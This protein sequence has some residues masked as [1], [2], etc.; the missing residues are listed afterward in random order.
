MTNINLSDADMIKLLESEDNRNDT[1]EL[2]YYTSFSQK[3]D[4]FG[5]YLQFESSTMFMYF[6]KHE[7]P[8]LLGANSAVYRGLS[9]ANYR[10]FN[11]AQR[12]YKAKNSNNFKD[13]ES[14]HT[15]IA[16][17]ITNAGSVNNGVLPGF[18][19]ATGLRNTHIPILSFL[20]H[21]G[22]PTPFMDWTTD[23]SVALFFAIMGMK[24]D[25]IDRYHMHSVEYNINDYI[26]LAILI[27]EHTLGQINE[28]RQLKATST[29]AASYDKLRKKKF[30][31][32]DE[33]Y[34]SGRPS[35]SLMN[36][37]HIVNQKGL[38]IYHSSS[39]L[40]LEE[41]FFKYW[42][43]YYLINTMLGR[44]T[45]RS[46][47]ICIDIHKS[48]AYHIREHLLETGYTSDTIF[49]KPEEIALKSIPAIF[50]L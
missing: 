44:T 46:P 15:G 34:K 25:E 42:K 21:Y 28:F 29:G 33:T 32:I 48:I 3:K 1:S 43:G 7:L 41:V 49:T 40:P 14:Y 23:I 18:L 45:P 24:D 35:L 11:K 22:A 20:Q 50:T 10:L 4:I 38:F 17:L 19:Q 16:E 39:Y 13:E 5:T 6:I 31:F 9:A 30:Q 47:I 8:N 12:V 26:S 27:K 36:N 2:E 37:F